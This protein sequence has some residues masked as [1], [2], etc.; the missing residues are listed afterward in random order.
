MAQFTHQFG[1]EVADSADLGVGESV[2]L[3]L[4]QQVGGELPRGR[5]VAGQVD[6]E[7]ELVDEPRVDAGGLEDLLRGGTRPQRP[8]HQSEPAVV[9][10]GA[11]SQQVGHGLLDGTGQHEGGPRVLQRSQGLA[12]GLNFAVRSGLDADQVIE[13][14]KY[15]AAQSWQSRVGSKLAGV[16]AVMS[17]LIS[18]RV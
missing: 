12:E 17:L 4:A 18:S 6:H 5:E 10:P 1:G 11:A 8:H 14:V 9:R 15:G 3:R 16:S 13:V 7:A 2:P